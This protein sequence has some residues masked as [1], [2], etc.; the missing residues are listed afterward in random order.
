MQHFAMKG[1]TAAIL[2]TIMMVFQV[3]AIAAA[4]ELST[5]QAIFVFGD[6]AL[7]IG[8]NIYVPGGAEVGEPTRADQPYYGMDFPRGTPTGRF[9]NGYNL[10]DFIGNQT[11]TQQMGIKDKIDSEEL[12]GSA[13]I[14]SSTDNNMAYDDKGLNSYNENQEIKSGSNKE[15]IDVIEEGGVQDK[16]L[17]K[18]YD[19]NIITGVIQTADEEEMASANNTQREANDTM[20]GSSS[21][22]DSHPAKGSISDVN[23]NIIG[24]SSNDIAQQ[25]AIN[26]TEEEAQEYLKECKLVHIP[27]E[28]A[29]KRSKRN[30]GMAGISVAERAISRVAQLNDTSV[31]VLR[32]MEEARA[33]LSEAMKDNQP[34]ILDMNNLKNVLLLLDEDKDK[35]REEKSDDDVNTLLVDMFQ[36]LKKKKKRIGS[37]AK[38]KKAKQKNKS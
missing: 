18:Q 8:N 13:D 5:P 16:S 7:D 25:D 32:E 10:A 11:P 30:T 38:K 20:I 3:L 29:N 9:S 21:K 14:E 34:E 6:G 26:Q 17:G 27:E 23:S 4:M 31:D 28:Q 2:T 33:A 37:S 12:S 22:N 1:S 35:S 15:T 24:Y 19:I 36:Q